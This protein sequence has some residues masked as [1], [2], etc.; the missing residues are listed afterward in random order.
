M[1]AS[2]G[3]FKLVGSPKRK[4]YT[5]PGGGCSTRRQQLR[6]LVTQT[7]VS[8]LSHCLSMYTVPAL[9][10]LNNTLRAIPL[11]PPP[12]RRTLPL[13][14]CKRREVNMTSFFSRHL[15]FLLVAVDVLVVLQL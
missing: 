14:F 3:H 15:V 6:V 4:S 13:C 2:M 8:R 9:A 10:S 1:A 12:S 7:E 11:L 5:N